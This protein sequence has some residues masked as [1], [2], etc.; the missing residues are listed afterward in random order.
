M[1]PP[2]VAH[3]VTRRLIP[4]VVL[5]LVA[6]ACG[7]STEG[8]ETVLTPNETTS[9][10][11]DPGE[12]FAG[13]E[14]APEFPDGL[15]WLNVERPLT[16]A[17][18]RG[19]LV[20]LDFWTYGCINCIHI[21]PDL[22]RLEAEYGDELVVIGVHSAKFTNEGDTENI[23]Q[24]IARYGLQ[25]PV[26]NDKDF[27]V[28]TTWGANAWPTVVLID[29]A[30]NIVGGHAGEGIYPIFQ[31]VIDSLVEEFD[32]RGQIDRSP[33]DLDIEQPPS[34][35]LSFPGKVLADPIGG[36]LFIAD[37]NHHRIVIADLDTG[38]VIDVA[39]SGI[40]GFDGGGFAGASF[41]QPQGMALGDG[42]TTLFVAD[43]GN[44]A[45]RLLDLE[46]R[47]VSTLAGDGEQASTYPPRPGIVPDVELASPWDL[48][49]VDNLLYVAM[50][51]SH[52]LWVIDLDAA[53]LDA[54]A[55]SGREGVANGTRLLAELAQPSG[56]AVDDAGRVYFADSESS[57]IRWA[58]SAADGQVGLAA[59][60]PN[61]LF[62][63][64]LVDGTG[65]A[66]RFQ[67]PLGLVHV[68]GMLFVA[69]TYNSAL[70]VIDL[71]TS[72]VTTL[73]GGAQGWADGP[74]P[75]FS[76]PGG[77]AY[78]DGWLFVADTNNHVVRR[79]DPATGAA[80]TIVLYGIERFP[81]SG[82]A[83]SVATVT[84]DSATV[85]PGPGT[86]SFELGLPGGYK[87]NDIAPLTI[88]WSVEGG[89][90]GFDADVFSEVEPALP[91]EIPVT[92]VAGSG[93][94][95]ADATIYYCED[96]AAELCLVHQVVLEVPVTVAD[97]ASQSVTLEYQIPDP[98]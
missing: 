73:A 30:G 55:G 83:M 5:A 66:A 17:E 51:G 59:G 81:Y 85:A 95:R 86:I 94:I 7:G 49:L 12:S 93:T 82:A 19:K 43:L 88:V 77:I 97:G 68:D 9:T 74:Q 69:D 54:F 87:L 22:E 20:L 80:E 21:I 76:E 2:S 47:T 89:I 78:A 33:I 56:L 41:D 3:H 39:G 84:L 62:D 38:E 24:V 58:D 63:F 57:S 10:T 15:E 50:A 4:I 1:S 31:P 44:H 46:E 98:A 34:T 79:V 65:D 70:R 23:R 72:E 27:T 96:E 35:V 42:G 90:A 60:S 11:I 6:A 67:H 64:G 13:T 18:L 36:R 14:Q 52:Q 29:P 40:S 45:V 16:L 26:V 53:R 48:L 25:H 75:R 32:A 61:G 37:T 28:W 92:F 8:G 91:V 71:A